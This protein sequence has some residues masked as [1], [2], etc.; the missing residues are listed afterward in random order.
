M[1]QSGNN[2]QG[3]L[4]ALLADSAK[5]VSASPEDELLDRLAARLITHLKAIDGECLLPKQDV[6]GS[7]PVTRSNS[8]SPHTLLDSQQEAR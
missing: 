3:L 4:K 6:T 5:R 8:I 1:S 2:E 7:N